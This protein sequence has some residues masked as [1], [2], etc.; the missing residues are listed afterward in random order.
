MGG[1]GKAG[2][3]R[4]E[5]EVGELRKKFRG[6]VCLRTPRETK[7]RGGEGRGGDGL[8]E[9]VPHHFQIGSAVTGCLA[10]MWA[11]QAGPLIGGL[12]CWLRPADSQRTDTSG[13]HQL[14]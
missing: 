8:G 6:G 5:R 12:Q 4:E 1:E 9:V 7:R 11:L 14:T 10:A 2:E 3:G 13:D